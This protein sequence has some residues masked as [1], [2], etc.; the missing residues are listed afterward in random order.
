MNIFY[1]C[2]LFNHS[3]VLY[4]IQDTLQMWDKLGNLFLPEFH[5]FLSDQN[6]YRPFNL[7]FCFPLARIVWSWASRDSTSLFSPGLWYHGQNVNIYRMARVGANH[8][9]CLYQWAT[10]RDESQD[11]PNRQTD[12][13]YGNLHHKWAG[14]PRGRRSLAGQ[15]GSILVGGVRGEAPEFLEF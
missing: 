6:Q 4:I 12:K 13:V 2:T 8:E 14:V 5:P 11:E 3:F 1:I 15:R 7:Y 10:G 9:K